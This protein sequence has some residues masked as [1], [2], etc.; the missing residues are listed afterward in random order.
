MSRVEYL[1]E[2][3]SDVCI[4]EFPGE[5]WYFWDETGCHIYGPFETEAEAEDKLEEHLLDPDF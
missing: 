4:E 2:V 5:G 1:E 3:P